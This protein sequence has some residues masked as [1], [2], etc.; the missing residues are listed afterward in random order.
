MSNLIER[1]APLGGIIFVV[2]LIIGLVLIADS[3]DFDASDQEVT[4]Y[5]NDDGNLVRNVIGFY[6]WGVAAMAFL[7]FA[8]GVRTELRRAEGESSALST[9]GF[10]AAIVFA[11]ML[12]A[13]GGAVASVAGAIEFGDAT[14][15]APD[16]VRMLP[17][18]G[19]AMLLVG[20]AF[21]A[22]IFLLS[23]SALTLKTGVL[24]QWIAWL[25][26]VA[27]IVLLFGALFIP[28]IAL[29]IWVLAA[30]IVLLMRR[31]ERTTAAA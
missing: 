19:F 6:M 7:W 9:L 16:F 18:L 3:P 14:K 10:G 20:G 2:L 11:A 27:A 12:L 8:S 30:S 5:L 25:G 13:A 24:P 31:Q 22:I 21:S 29:P 26:F 1:W 4:D 15:P 23:T 17:Q 28:M